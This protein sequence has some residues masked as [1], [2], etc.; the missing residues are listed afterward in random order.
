MSDFAPTETTLPS[1][2]DAAKEDNAISEDT[3]T[4][5]DL[6]QIDESNIVEGERSNKGGVSNK[7]DEAVESRAGISV[8]GEK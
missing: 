1:G 3:I 5:G 6:D 4:K 8:D 7:A 2:V